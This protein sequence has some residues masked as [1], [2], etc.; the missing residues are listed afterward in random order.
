MI[1]KSPASRKA[2]TDTTELNIA[3]AARFIQMQNIYAKQLQAS[4]L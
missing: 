3:Q 4:G 1:I 2:A